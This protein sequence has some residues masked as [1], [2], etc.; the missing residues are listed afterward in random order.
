M[1]N[2]NVCGFCCGF[3]CW[4]FLLF[5]IPVPDDKTGGVRFF[6]RMHENN[7]NFRVEPR[8]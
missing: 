3:D 7:G 6:N 4:K 5:R 1:I 8:I 2:S